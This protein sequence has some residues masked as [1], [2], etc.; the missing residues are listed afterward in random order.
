[1]CYI[2]KPQAYY[3]TE[4]PRTQS[5]AEISSPP[6]THAAQRQSWSIHQLV[7]LTGLSRPEISE[8]VADWNLKTIRSD[9]AMVIGPNPPRTPDES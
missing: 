5:D 9:A 7:I 1:M 4:D 8:T 6:N 2:E 3:P